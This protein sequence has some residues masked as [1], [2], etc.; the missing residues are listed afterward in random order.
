MANILYVTNSGAFGGMERHVLD[1]IKTQKQGNNIFV[2][3]PEGPIV[4]FYKNSGAVVINKSISSE[5]D[6]SYILFLAKV[7]NENKIS[8]THSHE[9]KAVVNTL[10]ASFICRVK[11]RITHTHTPIS[12]W[13]VPWYKKAINLIT[14]VSFVNLFSSKE[15]ALTETIKMIKISEGI[16]ENKLA[17][18]PNAVDYDSF[19]LSDFDKSEFRREVF[20]K[21]RI[22][23]NS[24]VIGNMSRL[25][26]EKDHKTLIKAFSALNIPGKFLLIAGGGK[27]E[28]F[29]KKMLVDEGINSVSV[30]TGIYTDEDKVKLYSAF[31]LIAF[32]SLAEGFGYVLAES[33]SFGVPVIC[34]NIDVLKEVGGDNVNYFETGN[35]EDLKN[36]IVEI[37]TSYD[38]AKNDAL[39]A[40]ERIKFMYSTE[41]FSQAYKSLYN[42]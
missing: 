3:C 29:Y 15:I 6:I 24:F 41:T 31:S 23:E 4:E 14:Y 28:E 17:V 22:P 26:E 32:T 37:S 9:V 8:I 11:K 20:E 36:R 18:I 2:V 40:K 5:I 7:I 16:R 27:M 13:S 38:K 25:T 10:I 39:S 30:I 19:Q 21:Y 12:T 33:M 1:L 42:L 34:S 35:F